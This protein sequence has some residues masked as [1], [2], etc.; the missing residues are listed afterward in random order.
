MLLC[1]KRL[2]L[3][4]KK[5]P[6]SQ[7][8]AILKRSEN[9]SNLNKMSQLFPEVSQQGNMGVQDKALL[10]MVRSL[11]SCSQLW[12]KKQRQFLLCSKSVCCSI[13]KKSVKKKRMTRRTVVTN[14]WSNLWTESTWSCFQGPIRECLLSAGCSLV[15]D[16]KRGTWVH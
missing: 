2:C 13:E 10:K 5:I 9:D 8:S 1:N 16:M 4:E 7:N 15:R 14:T 3:G 12:Q 6:P 11:D